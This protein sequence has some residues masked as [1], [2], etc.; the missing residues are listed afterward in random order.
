MNVGMIW[1]SPPSLGF[2]WRREKRGSEGMLG[3]VRGDGV[4]VV[5]FS[6]YERMNDFVM[7]K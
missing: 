3:G 7:V 6:F 2:C 1:N 5:D 4:S